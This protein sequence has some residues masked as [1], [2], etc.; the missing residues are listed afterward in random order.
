MVPFVIRG[1]GNAGPVVLTRGRRTGRRVSLAV[2][3]SEAEWTLTAVALVREFTV[4]VILT[5][6]AQTLVKLRLTEPS[7]EMRWA[8]AQLSLVHLT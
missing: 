5:R 2:H 6:V 1:V 7:G 8:I 3:S 4:T